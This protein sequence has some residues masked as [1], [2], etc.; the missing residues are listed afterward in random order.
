[1][2]GLFKQ[3]CTNTLNQLTNFDYHYELF[4]GGAG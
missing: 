2:A 4:I 1:M 3:F